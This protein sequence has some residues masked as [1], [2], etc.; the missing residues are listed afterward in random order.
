MT[1]TYKC[2]IL[3]L[4]YA[5]DVNIEKRYPREYVSL[6]E[7]QRESTP[8]SAPSS[9]SSPSPLSSPLLEDITK[10]IEQSDDGRRRLES[11]AR[12]PI[13]SAST[14]SSGGGIPCKRPI[15]VSFLTEQPPTQHQETLRQGLLKEAAAFPESHPDIVSA[16][17]KGT[18]ERDVNQ[19]TDDQ[20]F[21]HAIPASSAVIYPEASAV[22]KLTTSITAE[23]VKKSAGNTVSG[24]GMFGSL[25][26]LA[27]DAF[28]GAKHATEQ[29]AQAAQHAASISDLSTI[30]KVN[31]YY[32]LRVQFAYEELMQYL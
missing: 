24:I 27:G 28:K 25:S 7:T 19:T 32:L 4:K 31:Y 26:R 9:S 2:N 1:I 22:S 18:Q 3:D 11:E 16:P 17:V 20:P 5:A 30:S 8:P 10:S 6:T 14:S 13:D 12:V 29:I 23:K 21:L 15:D